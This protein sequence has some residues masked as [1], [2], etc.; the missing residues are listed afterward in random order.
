MKQ[1]PEART[2]GRESQRSEPRHLSL[3]PPARSGSAGQPPAVRGKQMTLRARGKAPNLSWPLCALGY[4]SL[5]KVHFPIKEGNIFLPPAGSNTG[6]LSKR[7]YDPREGRREKV[8]RA[9]VTETQRKR[10]MRHK[11]HHQSDCEVPD[12][13]D[14]MQGCG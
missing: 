7:T 1:K 13:E 12:T 14:Y 8:G 11:K 4:P 5:P 2:G 3:S 6:S 9:P 10:K